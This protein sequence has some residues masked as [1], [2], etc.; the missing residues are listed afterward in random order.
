MC[1]WCSPPT[2]PRL[3]AI[4]CATSTAAWPIS[5]A[6]CSAVEPSALGALTSFATS[7][8]PSS[9]AASMSAAIGEE[10]K[11][12]KGTDAKVAY[13]ARTLRAMQA[14]VSALEKNV[15]KF[16]HT[17]TPHCVNGEPTL[18]SN[19]KGVLRAARLVELSQYT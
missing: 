4:R 10:A 19:E 16:T 7:T 11:P 6:Q 1:G 2:P 18:I 12:A 9:L 15:P 5:A 13:G 17:D 3:F 8:P 14:R